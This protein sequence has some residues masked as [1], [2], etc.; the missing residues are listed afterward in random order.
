MKRLHISKHRMLFLAGGVIVILRLFHRA[1]TGTYC[2][3][4][5]LGFMQ[6][7]AASGSVP[8]GMLPGVLAALA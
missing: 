8:F 6:V 1:G 7:T 3:L 4:C 2:T 5:P